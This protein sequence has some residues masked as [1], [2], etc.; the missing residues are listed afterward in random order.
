VITVIYA[1]RKYQEIEIW[2]WFRS[3]WLKRASKGNLGSK[4]P[5]K[6]IEIKE[7]GISTLLPRKVWYDDTVQRLNGCERRVIREFRPNDKILIIQQS[8]KQK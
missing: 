3:L 8:G 2:Y 6:K 1:G 7:K 5:I 4:Y